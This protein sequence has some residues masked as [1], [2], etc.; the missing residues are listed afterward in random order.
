MCSAET[1]EAGERDLFA[2]A[3]ESARSDDQ[4]R[5]G[6][7]SAPS[8]C[9][10]AGSLCSA[11]GLRQ[12]AAQPPHPRRRAAL[13]GS[14]STRAANPT[15]PS[16]A[17]NAR[18][19]PTP[20]RRTLAQSRAGLPAVGR[21]AAAIAALNESCGVT[22]P[23][24]D[25]EQPGRQPAHRRPTAEAERAVGQALLLDQ[26]LAAGLF[27]L[28][29]CCEL[30][31]G[32]TR[33]SSTLSG[34]SGRPGRDRAAGL[35]HR[36][37]SPGTM[38]TQPHARPRL[39]RMP[40]K[41]RPLRFTFSAPA[42]KSAGRIRGCGAVVRVRTTADPTH[43]GALCELLPAQATC[44][45]ARSR[46]LRGRFRLGVAADSPIFAVLSAERSFLEGRQRRCAERWSASFLDASRSRNSV[47]N[48]LRVGYLFRGLAPARDGGTR[49]G[50]LRTS[51]SRG[52]TII[53][54]STGPNDRSPMRARLE[55]GFDRFVDAEDWP[56]EQLAA[57]IDADG[58]DLLIDLKGHTYA[59]TTSVL[60]LRPAP[61][62]ASYLGIPARWAPDSSTI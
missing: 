41:P 12:A 60:A 9:T 6:R 59:A 23:T 36:S 62:Q 55:A 17:S 56:P 29:L 43:G 25:L 61:V 3:K 22:A 2:A 32:S 28:A 15:P 46:P 16:S 57:Q 21:H 20:G 38:T 18:S 7:F 13:P 14:R 31:D 35:R 19:R 42:S 4:F 24:R 47:D 45:L 50:A 40:D 8:S 52:F 53:G 33:R 37:R 58:I 26:Q 39:Q 30:R 34:R 51:R 5:H 27:N 11:R 10:S 54:Y 49:G 48:V 44:R 1:H